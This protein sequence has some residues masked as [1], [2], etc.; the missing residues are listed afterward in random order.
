MSG[1]LDNP[2]PSSS[3]SSTS[4]STVAPTSLF[5]QLAQRQFDAQSRSMSQESYDDPSLW[6]RSR[7]PHSSSSPSTRTRTNRNTELSETDSD[8]VA[9]NSSEYSSDSGDSAVLQREWEE[10]LDQMKLM[11]QIIIFP[12]V[13]KFFGRKFGYFRKYHPYTKTEKEERKCADNCFL[14]LVVIFVN[15]GIKVFNRY[16]VLGSPFAGAFWRGV[17]A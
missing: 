9:S 15:W 17:V 11:F 1:Y 14:I 4:Q 16:R 12:F 5:A 10:Q 8:D 2:T 3:T 6:R 13:G 7:K